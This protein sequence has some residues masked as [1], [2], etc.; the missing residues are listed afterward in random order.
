MKKTQ[1]VHSIFLNKKEIAK[2]DNTDDNRIIVILIDKKEVYKQ[3]FFIKENFE[4]LVDDTKLM[5][6]LGISS[7]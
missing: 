6:D 7:F 5:R 4:R 2:V 3:V 1:G